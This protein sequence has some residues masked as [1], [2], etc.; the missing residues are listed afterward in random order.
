MALNGLVAYIAFF[1]FA[2]WTV[3]ASLHLIFGQHPAQRFKATCTVVFRRV[4][5]LRFTFWRQ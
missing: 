4:S 5:H 1:A 3:L 2:L